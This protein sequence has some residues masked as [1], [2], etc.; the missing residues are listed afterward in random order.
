M[1]DIFDRDQCKV[2]LNGEEQYSIWP[3][4]LPNPGGWADAGFQ[5]TKPDC[6]AWIEEHWTDLRPRSL[7]EQMQHGAG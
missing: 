3:V 2:V 6:L 4:T 1:A 7:R 5:G